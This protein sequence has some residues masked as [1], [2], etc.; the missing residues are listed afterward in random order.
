MREAI[1]AAETIHAAALKRHACEALLDMKGEVLRLGGQLLTTGYACDRDGRPCPPTD[2]R[3]VAWSPYGVFERVLAQRFPAVPVFR[4]HMHHACAKVTSNAIG[5][6]AEALFD[7]APDRTDFQRVDRGMDWLI[8]EAPDCTRLP[9]VLQLAADFA[10][11]VPAERMIE[12]VTGRPAESW[13]PDAYPPGA[14]LAPTEAER[15]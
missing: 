8:R 5:L 9:D 4:F 2:R 6:A 14:A 13:T 12:A 10:R 15:A 3:A 1:I 11:E 7:F